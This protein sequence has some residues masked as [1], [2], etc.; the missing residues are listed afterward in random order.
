M[1]DQNPERAVDALAQSDAAKWEAAQ[2]RAF[3]HWVNT[4][5]KR[6]EIKLTD[7][8]HGFENGVNLIHLSEVLT[9]KSIQQKWSKNPNTRI[10]MITN[11]NLAIQHLKDSGVCLWLS[12]SDRSL[13]LGSKADGVR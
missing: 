8:I 11:A 3:L 2:T 5:L 6:R 9:G 1:S 13:R 4:I 10:H 12:S 7:L